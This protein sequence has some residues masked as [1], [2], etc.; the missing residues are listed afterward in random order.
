MKQT[1]TYEPP[2]V[3]II[4]MVMDSPILSASSE[5]FKT[6]QDYDDDWA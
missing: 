2:K 4:V 3:D 6:Q 1:P 5:T